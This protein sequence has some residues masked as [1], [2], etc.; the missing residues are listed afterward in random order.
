MARAQEGSVPFVKP[1][2]E[3]AGKAEQ[4]KA[5]ARA[6]RHIY[7]HPAPQQ[8]KNDILRKIAKAGAQKKGQAGDA[9]YPGQQAAQPVVPRRKE[10]QGKGKEEGVPYKDG[11][12]LARPRQRDAPKTIMQPSV[13]PRVESKAPGS[14]PK[15]QPPTKLTACR[16]MARLI[17]RD[18]AAT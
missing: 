16:G 3:D 15:A 8:G 2:R 5:K 7:P 1:C 10:A 12:Q 6:P 4:H 11:V 13:A 17:K 14:A 18:E 9:A